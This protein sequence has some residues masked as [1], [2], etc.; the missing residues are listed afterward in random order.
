MVQF[1]VFDEFAPSEFGAASFGV[2]S[3]AVGHML[4]E[5]VFDGVLRGKVDNPELW[6]TL[7]TSG[8]L[9]V[10]AVGAYLYGRK[11]GLQWLQYVAGGIVFVEIVQI[12]DL[13]RVQF[14]L[15]E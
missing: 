1:R 15:K 13:I 3:G 14:F 9:T 8:I 11:P 2:V 12:L 6:S 10:F 4:F 5:S 7:I